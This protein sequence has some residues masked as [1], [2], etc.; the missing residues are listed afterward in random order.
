MT[1][2]KLQDRLAKNAV[3]F[4]L[5]GQ[6]DK[7]NACMELFQFMKEKDFATIRGT[8]EFNG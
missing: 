5:S 2:A 6:A 8:V 3:D 1:F 4:L 7:S